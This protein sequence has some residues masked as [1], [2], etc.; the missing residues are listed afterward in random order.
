MA[1]SAL[2]AARELVAVHQRHQDVGDHQLGARFLRARQ[3]LAPVGR[4]DDLVPGDLEQRGQRLA[5]RAVVVR[6]EDGGHLEWTIFAQGR[7][8]CLPRNANYFVAET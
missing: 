2:Q 6:D 1:G 7:A 3:R 8:R 5:I 4:A